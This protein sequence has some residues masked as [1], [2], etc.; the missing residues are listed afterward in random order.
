LRG[1]LDAVEEEDGEG[2]GTIVENENEDEN[3]GVGNELIG[4]RARIKALLCRLVDEII[5]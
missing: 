5:R 3:E 1:A 4:R 2:F